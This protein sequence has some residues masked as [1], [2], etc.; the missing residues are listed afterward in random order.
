MTHLFIL[1]SYAV[2]SAAAG[3]VLSQS[4]T[5]LAPTTCYLIA[6]AGFFTAALAHE[7]FS[8]RIEQRDMISQLDAAFDEI[9]EMR[10]SNLDLTENLVRARE[11]MVVLSVAVESAAAGTNEA[12]VREMKVLRSQ[13]GHMQKVERPRAKRSGREWPGDRPEIM[14]SA[15]D[16][17]GVEATINRQEILGH[18]REALETNRIDLYLQPI[19]SLPQRRTRHY[20]AFSRIRTSDGRIVAAQQYLEVAK[21]EGLIGTIDN[22]LLMRCVQLLRRNEK[23][24]TESSFFVNISQHTLNDEGFLAQ[25]IDFMASNPT[26]AARLIFEIAQQDVAALS[27]VA[28]AQ[29]GRLGEL[30]FRFSMDQVDTLE[31]DFQDLAQSHFRFIK[32]P[33]NLLLT[34]P[35]DGMNWVHPRNLK[36]KSAVSEINLVVERI[37]QESDVIEM[38]EY[39][40]DYGQGFLFGAPRPS[41]EAARAA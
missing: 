7:I 40:F 3:F 38:L 1:A 8:R 18:I 27:K 28:L 21:Q 32:I 20:E 6:G 33:I 23:R 22:L 9:D 29:L 13:L 26:L 15:S 11:E 31:I 14:P 2:V 39:G 5:Q 19:V 10:E 4:L 36:A 17:S 41:R 25:F 34:L 30:G 37:E 16:P 24:Q 35:E 12:L